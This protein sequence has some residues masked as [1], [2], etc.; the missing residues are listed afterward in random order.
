MVMD[1]LHCDNWTAD[2]GEAAGELFGDVARRYGEPARHYHTLD[3]VR[4]VL[5][6]ARSLTGTA[7]STPLL[8]AVWLHDVIYEPRAADNEERSAD[9]ARR[10]AEQM[11]LSREVAEE[12]ARLILLTKTHQTIADDRDGQA[13]LDADLAILGEDEETYD[14]YAAAIRR[15]YDWVSEPDYR[16]GRRRVLE[17]F[18][19]RPHIYQTSWM[20]QHHEGSARAN[21]AREIARLAPS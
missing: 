7:L 20:R 10:A 9:Y 2:F 19:A 15:E 5:D 18:L 1:A 11:G 3:H 21:L 16:A 17:R 8:L 12:T 6:T 14:T 4:S 13:L